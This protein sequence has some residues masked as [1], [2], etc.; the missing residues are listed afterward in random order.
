MLQNRPDTRFHKQR[1]FCK[2]AVPQWTNVRPVWFFFPRILH[3]RTY[4]IASVLQLRALHQRRLEDGML[5]LYTPKG[6]GCNC[7]YQIMTLMFQLSKGVGPLK[8]TRH[9]R[10]YPE[11]THTPV[12]LHGYPQ[13]STSTQTVCISAQ[14]DNLLFI[15]TRDKAEGR[16]RIGR[17]GYDCANK[18]WGCSPD[19]QQNVS[20][21]EIKHSLPELCIGQNAVFFFRVSFSFLLV[22]CC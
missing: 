17:K 3:I 9:V 6:V 11:K 5:R 2:L 20:I 18:H 12:S 15:F 14:F 13:K 22:Y 4:V 8:R 21:N 7:R 19:R 10:K 16:V 1:T